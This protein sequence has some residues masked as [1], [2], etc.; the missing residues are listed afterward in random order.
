MRGSLRNCR[1]IRPGS[2]APRPRGADA[3]STYSTRETI[4]MAEKGFRGISTISPDT[5]ESVV[6]S[7]GRISVNVT[8]SNP[9]TSTSAARVKLYR[10]TAGLFEM[11]P[12]ADAS[13]PNAGGTTTSF[14][15]TTNF[16]K[17]AAAIIPGTNK[18]AVWYQIIPGEWELHVVTI[19]VT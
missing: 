3:V 5:S 2:F 1:V 16:N 4:K 15:W 11:S 17:P 10:A 14:A 7:N 8:L 9:A 6:S 18:L 13:Q 12:P 19:S